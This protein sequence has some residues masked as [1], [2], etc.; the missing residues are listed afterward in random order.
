MK[1]KITF[2]N[3]RGRIEEVE[4]DSFDLK[5]NMIFFKDLKTNI[6]RAIPICKCEVES[7]VNDDS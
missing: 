6:I 1:W 3:I 7:V 4:C 2:E 5:G